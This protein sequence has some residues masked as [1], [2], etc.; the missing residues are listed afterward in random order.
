MKRLFP[1]LALI[2]L[3]SLG[4]GKSEKKTEK[5]KEVASSSQTAQTNAP[6]RIIARVNGKPIYE[7]DL[8]G[9]PLEYL[10][11]DEILYQDGL[12]SGL[13]KKLEPRIEQ[14]KKSLIVNAMKNEIV[15]KLPKDEEVSDKEI[16]DY[17]KAN[18]SRYT[19]MHVKEMTLED[20]SLAEEAHKR[21][22]SGEDLEKIA[23][24]LSAKSGKSIPVKDL[25]YGV[26]YN[27]IFR[28]KN[29]GSVSDV[30]QEGNEFK[31]V[32]LVEV[33]KI[34]LLRAGQSIKYLVLAK[35]KNDAMRDYAEKLS[36]E[37]NIKVEILGK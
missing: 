25:V 14:F 24:D 18:E 13:D 33:R 37:D 28:G 34:P 9:R 19:H 16:E 21:A 23:S 15:N 7:K 10:I 32:K 4:C 5:P 27:E 35:K 17:Y 3:V 31:V 1:L 30:I 6:D 36:K 29:P 8:G 12:K 22:L 2:I 20:K 11:T 26:R